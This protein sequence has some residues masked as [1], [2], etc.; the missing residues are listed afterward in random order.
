MLSRVGLLLIALAGRRDRRGRAGARV[1]FRRQARSRPRRRPARGRAARSSTS[2]PSGVCARAG[3]PVVRHV[4]AHDRAAGDRQLHRRDHDDAVG[5]RATTTTC[6]VYG[7]ERR[8]R[9]ELD[10]RDAAPSASYSRI[11]AA[12]VVPGQ[13]RAVARRRRAARTPARRRSPSRRPAAVRPE[14]GQ[15]D[16]RHRGPAGERRGPA[17]RRARRLRTGRARH[18]QAARRDPEPPAAGRAH[19]A[20]HEPERRR[21]AV[22]ARHV[23]ADQPRP[24]LLRRARS[25]SSS[26]TSTSWKPQ[27]VHAPVGLHVR[28]VRGDAGQLARPA[29]SR[30]RT[31]R[32][33]LEGYNA[34]R[35]TFR[36]F[37]N[38]VAPNAPVRFVDGEKTEDWIAANSEA[39]PRL[40]RPRSRQGAGSEPRLHGLRAQHVGLGRGAGA[41]PARQRVPRLQGQPHRPR[42]AATSTASTGRASGAVATAS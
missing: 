4:L 21:G 41:D 5:G 11:P 8:H 36:G 28:A 29:T 34:T 10:D 27:V 30:S 25:R 31:N 16:V 24:R 35:G 22:P 39:V 17:P 1:R 26:R 37:G 38:T 12:G 20:R 14:V 19:P 32:A 23:D 15:V 6:I 7:A 3:R 18:A 33:Y 9:R 13:R 40:G 42:H 2:N